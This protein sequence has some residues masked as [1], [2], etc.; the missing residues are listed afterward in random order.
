MSAIQL[1]HAGQVSGDPVH[2]ARLR[3][4]RIAADPAFAASADSGREPR[5]EPGRIGYAQEVPGV[6]RGDS[7]ADERRA[8]RTRKTPRGPSPQFMAQHIAQERIPDPRAALTHAEAASRYP[9]LARREELIPPGRPLAAFAG[10]PY[11]DFYA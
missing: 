11:I 8:P 5:R 3:A 6:E 1:Y 4:V 10:G 7:H 2:P 9:S